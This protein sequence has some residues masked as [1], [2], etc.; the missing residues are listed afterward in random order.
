[1]MATTSS[2]GANT[3]RFPHTHNIKEAE[4][5]TR[6][7]RREREKERESKHRAAAHARPQ[8]PRRQSPPA[9]CSPPRVGAGM[10]RAYGMDDD[11]G[12]G[13]FGSSARAGTGGAL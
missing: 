6:T 9:P 1:M 10:S 3:D 13:R 8:W 7:P 4:H 5:T 12:L 2:C 11:L